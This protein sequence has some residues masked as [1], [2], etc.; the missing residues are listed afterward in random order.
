LIAILV[1]FHT[2]ASA[3]SQAKEEM[4]TA[5][6]ELRIE[7]ATT[8]EDGSPQALRFTLTNVGNRAIELPM[9]AI[10]CTT[11]FGSIIVRSKVIAT[12]KD[13]FVSMRGHGCGSG[14]EGGNVSLLEEIRSSWFHLEPGEYLVFTGDGRR[15]LDK[16]DGSYTYEYWAEYT[17]PQLSEQDQMEA[18]RARIVIPLDSVASTHLT[19]TEKWPVEN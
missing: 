11:R 17:P 9:P 19:Y 8:N 3:Q 2:V 7:V 13:E 16:A 14:S 1:W 5:G 18:K 4:R 10:D 6:L 12:K 15:M